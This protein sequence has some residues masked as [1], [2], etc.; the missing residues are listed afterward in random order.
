MHW[1]IQEGFSDFIPLIET[2]ERFNI[3]YS[4]HKVVP[5]TGELVPEPKLDT[6]NVIC[7]GSY[8]MRHTSKKYG[9]YPGIFDVGHHDFLVQRSHWG[10]LMLNH[11][12]KIL[13]IRDVW[14]ERNSFIR[15]IDDS[16]TLNGRV[17]TPEEFAEWK[18]KAKDILWDLIVQISPVKEIWS[19][20]RFWIVDERIITA[21]QYK[22]GDRV[23][24]PPI[25]DQRFH[26]F[27]LGVAG[28]EFY[29]L[30]HAERQT[31]YTG[32]KWRPEKAFVLDLCETPDGIKIVEINTINSAGLYAA[33]VQKLVMALHSMRF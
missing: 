16:K 22:I 10:E 7:F 14:L 29:L 2:L 9:W 24:Y 19:E 21:S 18:P 30:P 8:S 11:D 25:V 4:L 31:R 28:S 6:N 15:P 12:S 17:W 32:R 26:N 1:I 23:S 3:S 20:Y 5:F 33:D 13:P 27:A